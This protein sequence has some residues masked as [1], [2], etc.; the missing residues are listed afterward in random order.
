M[1]ATLNP[2]R[3]IFAGF[4]WSGRTGRLQFFV[5]FLVTVLPSVV[6]VFGQLYSRFPRWVDV[7]L[8]LILALLTVPQIGH[9]MRRLNDAGRSGWWVWAALV[10]YTAVPLWI[11]LLLKGPSFSRPNAELSVARSIGF[12]LSIFLALVMASRVFWTPFTIPTGS[13]KPALLVGDYVVATVD[14]KLPERGDVIVFYG[15]EQGAMLVKRAIGLPGDRVQLRDGEV[16]LN[17]ELIR[18]V[19]TGLFREE[20]VKQ[21]PL[22]L[23]PRC[24]NGAVGTGAMCEKRLFVETLP[25]GRQYEVLNIGETALDNTAEITVPEGHVLVL[26]DNRDNSTDSRVARG[27]GG[28][29]LVP[30]E[31][32]VGHVRRVLFSTEG[33]TAWAVWA[34]RWDR[35]LEA[36]R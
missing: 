3:L 4:D 17:G 25:S 12:L 27:A 30:Q 7:L 14:R 33:S 29:G 23:F 11:Y 15:A 32:L 16:L 19:D 34:L 35:F 20:M 36:V 28:V 24:Y 1:R 22:G 18:Q 8:I 13:M 6:F 31:E 5:V 21:G 10:P 9:V 26:G 2:L